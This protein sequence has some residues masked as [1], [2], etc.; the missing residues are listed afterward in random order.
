MCKILDI[1]VYIKEGI[2]GRRDGGSGV[3]TMSACRVPAG[4]TRT[5]RGSG[6]HLIKTVAAHLRHFF[7]FFFVFFDFSSRLSF[8][9]K[10]MEWVGVGMNGGL[11]MCVCVRICSVPQ[12]G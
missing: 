8:E 7:F 2:D 11:W 9:A 5:A 1:C 3:S 12:M 4:W 10:E 6:R